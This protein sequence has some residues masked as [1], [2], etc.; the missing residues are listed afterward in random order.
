MPGAPGN[1]TGN[2]DTA[3]NELSDRT[4]ATIMLQN[5]HQVRRWRCILSAVKKSA[6]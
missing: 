5:V 1:L 2:E 3:A 6:F 4:T